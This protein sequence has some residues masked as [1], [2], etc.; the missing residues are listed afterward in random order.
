MPGRT[1]LSEVLL[2]KEDVDGGSWSQQ[3]P[4]RGGRGWTRVGQK[5]A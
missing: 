2:L 1:R 5:D 3:V 4:G